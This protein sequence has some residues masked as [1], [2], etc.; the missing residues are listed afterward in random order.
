MLK[1]LYLNPLKLGYF[2]TLGTSFAIVLSAG[3]QQLDQG[4]Q[5]HM[6]P[7]LLVSLGLSL[8]SFLFFVDGRKAQWLMGAGLVSATVVSLFYLFMMP[9]R[10]YF[11][12]CLLMLSAYLLSGVVTR[13]RCRPDI[14]RHD[15]IKSVLLMTALNWM[16]VQLF[17]VTDDTT[18]QTWL[19]FSTWL[20]LLFSIIDRFFTGKIVK[21]ETLWLAAGAVCIGIVPLFMSEDYLVAASRMTLLGLLACAPTFR[22]RHGVRRRFTRLVEGLF[23]HPDGVVITFFIGFCA[24]GTLALAFPFRGAEGG[25]IALIDAAFTAVSAV[26]VTGLTV[27]DTV[28]DFSRI[29]QVIILILIQIGGLG[30]MTLSSLALFLMGQRMSVT[31]EAALVG[32]IGQKKLKTEVR[33][34]LGRI[35]LFTLLVEMVGAFVL[36]MA[37]AKAGQPWTV[38][39]WKGVFTAIAAFCNAGFAL[40]SANLI[41]WQNHPLV[42]HTVAALIIIGGL[43]PAFVMAMPRL[44]REGPIPI[45]YRLVLIA[46]VALLLGGTVILLGTEWSASL[47]D[48]SVIDKFHN[49]WFLSVSTRTAGFNATDMST[50]SKPSIY[51]IMLLMFVGGSPG[52]TAGGIKTTTFMVLIFTA[53]N[54]I[55]GRLEVTMFGRHLKHTTVYRAFTVTLLAMGVATLAFLLLILS[56]PLASEPLL[57][58]VISALATTGLSLGITPQ[59]DSFGKI[60]IMACM[61]F[62]RVGALS[63]FIFMLEQ[64]IRPRWTLPSEDV[65]VS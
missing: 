60:V 63:I 32:V 4:H 35:L 19:V 22:F 21:K 41:P 31:Q 59:L 29:D 12:L 1:F 14:F 64:P 20:C 10:A 23:F 13:E 43:S 5:W 38:S 39:L 15:I 57:F 33:H 3:H 44:G 61:F 65:V 40:E 26:C 2:L 16:L 25:G 50:L 37:F 47:K 45:Q 36:T 62:G 9:A 42:L 51:V 55:R 46:T 53:A 49:S 30:I 24:I 8:I 6:E 34:T 7:G 17:R 18:A 48:L 27:L 11:V 58:E 52:G 28:K 54:I 56:Q